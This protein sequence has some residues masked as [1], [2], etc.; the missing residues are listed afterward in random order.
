MAM[1]AL[2]LQRPHVG[3]I[4][5][6]DHSTNARP[7][8]VW[9]EQARSRL[10]DLRVQLD[11]LEA[12]PKSDPQCRDA[13]RQLDEA[14]QIID[15]PPRLRC[16]WNGIDIQ[17][18]WFRIHAVDAAVIRFAKPQVVR[19][20]LQGIVADG[21]ELLGSDH[22][23]VVTLRE[24]ATQP[25]WDCHAREA[26]V[27][28]VKAVYDASDSENM[29]LRSFRNLLFGGTLALAMIAV[30]VACFDFV[31]R[32]LSDSTTSAGAPSILVIELLGLV[33]ASLVGA[34][35]L[36]RMEGT[37]TA[38]SVPMATMLLKLPA[39]AL[40][41][42]AGVLMIKAGVAGP[43]LTALNETHVMGYAL[44]LGA[45]QQGITGLVDRQAQKVLNGISSKDNA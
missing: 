42:V 13:R 21:A 32:G 8:S 7:Y 18:T 28:S 4:T 35:A 14:M 25:E 1:P 3:V 6:V 26:I 44:L 5:A 36:R 12:G 20:K 30:G 10:A 9:R 16:M 40:T 39:G 27:H 33:S 43:T 15:A 41:A 31:S 37:S 17:A 22:P 2:T 38:Y 34:L 19:A 45:S 11:E 24:L 29:R 23:R